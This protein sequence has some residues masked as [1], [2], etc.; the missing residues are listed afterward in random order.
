MDGGEREKERIKEYQS[1]DL[2]DLSLSTPY[3]TNPD[4]VEE[5]DWQLRAKIRHLLGHC[6]SLAQ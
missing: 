2:I 6:S 3:N 1:P 4:V 5:I